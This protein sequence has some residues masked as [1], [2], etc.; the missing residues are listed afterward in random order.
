MP[1]FDIDKI[2][3][4]KLT[5][6]DYFHYIF[7]TPKMWIPCLMLVLLIIVFVSELILIGLTLNDKH[8]QYCSSVA[9]ASKNFNTSLVGVGC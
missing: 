7:V 5:M 9:S 1:S 4:D 6:V 3:V 8:V 2:P